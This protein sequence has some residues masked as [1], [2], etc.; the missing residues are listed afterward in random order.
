[1]ERMFFF[2]PIPRVRARARIGLCINTVLVVVHSVVSILVMKELGR[3]LDLAFKSTESDAAHTSLT[4]L[5]VYCVALAVLFV[6]S[7]NFK[8]H[9]AWWWRATLQ[10]EYKCLK[11]RLDK[12]RVCLPRTPLQRAQAAEADEF[13]KNYGQTFQEH[14]LVTT[15]YVELFDSMVYATLS[16]LGGLYTLYWLDKAFKFSLDVP[17]VGV[18]VLV[19]VSVCLLDFVMTRLLGRKMTSIRKHGH[20]AEGELRALLDTGYTNQTEVS[21]HDIN[22][23]NVRLT[24]RLKDLDNVHAHLRLHQM[25][26][27]LWQGPYQV[28]FNIA[29]V[30][31]VALYA[32]HF[33]AVATFG[34]V[35]QTAG[36]LVLVKNGVSTFTANWSS[37]ISD[38]TAKRQQVS[39]LL[40]NLRRAVEQVE[41]EVQILK[42]QEEEEQR[43][44]ER[45]AQSVVEL[46]PQSA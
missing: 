44:R 25:L 29:P 6:V 46:F 1:M 33:S 36:M 23:F 21:I 43:E 34:M 15:A 22:T 5:V 9:Y 16:G 37:S 14:T 40:A 18:L 17:V 8:P 19:I 12:G 30:I 45:R 13:L 11:D 35:S 41:A 31:L 38:L 7:S 24:D 10:D 4:Y 28:L 26:V 2:H 32:S 3:Y 39:A 20:A 27:S 42:R